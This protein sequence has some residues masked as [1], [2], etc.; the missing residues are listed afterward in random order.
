MKK[1]IK[2]IRQKTDW[3]LIIVGSFMASYGIFDFKTFN[4][5]SNVY[6]IA[7]VYRIARA[8]RKDIVYAYGYRYSTTTQTIIAIGV[9]LLVLGIL[10]YKEKAKK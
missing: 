3:I 6:R 10:I 7:S 5:W 9:I 4:D 8:P 1:I 2:F